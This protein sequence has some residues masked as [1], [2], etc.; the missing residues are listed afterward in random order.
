MLD[1]DSPRWG[2]LHHAHGP[3][4]DLPDMLR[5]LPEGVDAIDGVLF[6]SICHQGSVFSASYA[7]M[8]H[9]C[10]AAARTPSAEWRGRILSVMGAI[11]ASTDFRGGDA[12]ADVRAWY[13][14]AIAPA[15]DLAIATL[16]E[17]LDRLTAIYLLEAAA[18]LQGHLGLGRVLSGFAGEEFSLSCQHCAIDL[19]VWPTTDGLSVA[20]DDPVFHP[21]TPRTSTMPG[22]VS[23]STQEPAYSWI[24]P[25]V[26]TAPSLG[27]IAPLL[28]HLFGTATCPACHTSFTL[29]DRLAEEAGVEPH[30]MGPS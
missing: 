30:S 23:G 20:A 15:R 5:R 7:A 28:P 6:G 4:S 2:N 12:P 22:P 16:Q 14:D 18:A 19:Y 10:H 25:L 17:P 13:R 9:L 26:L 21:G 3:A 11:H 29:V 1:L 24:T 8:P 27:R